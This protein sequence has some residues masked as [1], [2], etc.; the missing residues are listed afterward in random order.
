MLAFFY[1]CGISPEIQDLLKNQCLWFRGLVCW[2][3]RK[4][5][6]KLYGST[7]TGNLGS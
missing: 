3:F 2:D 5:E 1:P 4:L 7:D 6:K